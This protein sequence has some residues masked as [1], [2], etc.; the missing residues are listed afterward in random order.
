M[1]IN[2]YIPGD[3]QTLLNFPDIIECM[4]SS[5]HVVRAGVTPKFKDVSTLVSMLTNS[6]APISEQ[7]MSPT[8]YPYVTLS[9]AAYSSN[10]SA[11]LYDPP[12]EEFGVVKTDL[13]RAKAKATFD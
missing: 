4:A 9:A 2:I 5:E 8:D 13:N 7:K 12:I 10:S 3:V 1:S 6:Y 11:T